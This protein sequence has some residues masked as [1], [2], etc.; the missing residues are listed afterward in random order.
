VVRDL[1]NNKLKVSQIY[2]ADKRHAYVSGLRASERPSAAKALHTDEPLVG[3]RAA[4]TA[5]GGQSSTGSRPPRARATLIPSTCSCDVKLA[6][7]RNIYGELRRLQLEKYP[8]AISVLLRVF[9]EL[10]VDEIIEKA[11]LMGD[12]QRRGSKLRDKMTKV[13]D[14]LVTKGLLTDLQAKAAKRGAN[15]QHLIGG[16]V[17]TLHEYVHNKELAASPTDLRTAWDNVQP[18]FEA[19]WPRKGA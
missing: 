2:N 16:N 18:F 4:S 6:R 19:I 11:A 10:S 12:Q 3:G 13:A 8:N 5:A 7:L 15:D 14:H 17:T 1:A 9:L